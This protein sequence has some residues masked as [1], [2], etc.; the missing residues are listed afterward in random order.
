MPENLLWNGTTAFLAFIKLFQDRSTKKDKV[1]KRFG[2]R[3]NNCTPHH[4]PHTMHDVPKNT[5]AASCTYKASSQNF[6]L[7]RRRG[8]FDFPKSP[9]PFFFLHFAFRPIHFANVGKYKYLYK[10]WLKNTRGTFPPKF[11]KRGTHP[12]VFPFSD[13]HALITSFYLP[14]LWRSERHPAAS[15]VPPTYIFAGSTQRLPL[16]YML[17]ND[18]KINEFAAQKHEKCWL[19]SAYGG[20]WHDRVDDNRQRQIILWAEADRASCGYLITLRG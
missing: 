19:A 9:T 8:E 6:D 2:V 1:A 14:I 18:S 17:S 10:C 13:A 7:G 15:P 20:W 12:L 5:A 4:I 3:T 11:W 16:H